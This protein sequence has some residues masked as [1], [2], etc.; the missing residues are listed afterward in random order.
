MPM[1]CSCVFAATAECACHL[2]LGWPLPTNVLDLSPIFR[3]VSN[4][5]VVPQGKGLLG[6]LAYYGLDSIGAK[7]KDAMRRRILEGGPYSPQ[8]REEILIYCASDTDETADLLPKLLAEPEFNL[9]TALH[10]GEFAAVSALMEHRGIP[11]D[12][13]ITPQLL[14]QKMW[15]FVRDA[16]VPEIN[17]Q[18]RSA[19]RSIRNA[20]LYARSASRH[21][22]VCG[23]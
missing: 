10:W 7:R 14:D 8:E 20:A 16:V 23:A 1:C 9:H 19:R 21:F 18:N 12:A 5:R 22:N 17:A 3:C 2:A 13:E 11:I 15:S 4:G 6:A